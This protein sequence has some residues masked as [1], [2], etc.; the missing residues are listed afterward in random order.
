MRFRVQAVRGLGVGARV[1]TYIHAPV[2]TRAQCSSSVRGRTWLC[3]ALLWVR[4]NRAPGRHLLRLFAHIMPSTPLPL[5]P[6]T[7][8][9]PPFPH[10]SHPHRPG[11]AGPRTRAIRALPAR[12]RGRLQLCG[13]V[14]VHDAAAHPGRRAQPQDRRAGAAHGV[15]GRHHGGWVMGRA[16][17]CTVFASV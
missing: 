14:G 6:L 4:R 2:T 17:V 3:I 15:V 1:H 13:G 5:S 8:P 7:S 12:V 16:G 9:L 10:L 11:A